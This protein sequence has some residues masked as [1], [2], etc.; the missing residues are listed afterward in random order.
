MLWDCPV[1]CGSGP[2]EASQVQ[3]YSDCAF[4]PV[5]NNEL[6]R[7][8][9]N[10][11]TALETASLAAEQVLSRVHI[12]HDGRGLLPPQTELC[13]TRCWSNCNSTRRKQVRRRVKQ[14]A[15]YTVAVSSNTVAYVVRINHIGRPRRVDASNIS[16][17][18][19]TWLQHGVPC[20]HVLAVLKQTVELDGAMELMADCY[21]VTSYAQDQRAS[22]LPDHAALEADKSL[23]PARIQRQAGRPRKR[24]ICSRGE[25]GKAPRVRGVYKCGKCGIADGH[26]S[27]TCRALV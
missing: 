9:A 1:R 25:R 24:P 5:E 17:T 12:N 18:C 21:S 4:V 6:R 14:A 13:M 20:R 19:S 7:E 10:Q 26:H 3:R 15:V 8:R 2:Q 16:Y 11:V 27:A 22:E 23:L